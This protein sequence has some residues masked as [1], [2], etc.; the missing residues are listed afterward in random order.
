[1]VSRPRPAAFLR[2]SPQTTILQAF[3]ARNSVLID[4]W[5]ACSRTIVFEKPSLSAT[6]VRDVKNTRFLSDHCDADS[7]G[8]LKARENYWSTSS[9]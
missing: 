3:F 9:E 8:Y 5:P 1:L 6:V 4:N 2:F 7:S